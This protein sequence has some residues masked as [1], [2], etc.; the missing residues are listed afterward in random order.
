MSVVL[1]KRV[2]VVLICPVVAI[3]GCGEGLLVAFPPSVSITAEE[4]PP[5]TD[6]TK[7]VTAPLRL[8]NAGYRTLHVTSVETTCSCT[9]VDSPANLAIAPGAEVLL[10]VSASPPKFGRSHTSILIKTDSQGSPTL[11][12]SVELTG[13]MRKA[14][15][16]VSQTEVLTLRGAVGEPTQG[17][18]EIQSIETRNTLPAIDSLEPAIPHVSALGRDGVSEFPVGDELL[19]RRYVFDVTCSGIDSSGYLGNLTAHFA[20]PQDTIALR[21]RVLFESISALS[22]VPSEV[23]LPKADAATSCRMV[24]LSRDEAP[25]AVVKA[26]WHLNE[27]FSQLLDSANRA[28]DSTA[29][30]SVVNQ[31]ELQ[32]PI[33]PKGE[34]SAE[35]YVEIETTHPQ[36]KKVRVPVRTTVGQ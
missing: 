20:V 10:N 29:N 22:I 35:S 17:L 8:R 11:T 15:Y 16:V 14:P 24:L 18:I 7:P 3:A 25:F 36:T 12:V 28:T 26:T 2:R 21:T 31:F 23:E 1:W 32:F 30:G 4:L 34:L 19:L 27:R 5:G 13:D 6:A 9:S 33:P